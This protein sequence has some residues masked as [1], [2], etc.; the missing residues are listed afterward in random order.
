MS[1]SSFL[2]QLAQRIRTFDHPVIERLF[3]P[4]RIALSPTKALALLSLKQVRAENRFA[5]HLVSW[6]TF[7]SFLIL[8]NLLIDGPGDFWAPIP[9]GLWGIAIAFHGRRALRTRRR[10]YEAEHRLLRQA[11]SSEEETDIERLRHK[12]LRASEE[13]REV[14]RSANPDVA[15]EISHGE[16]EAL[17]VVAW[18]D[19]AEKLLGST[20]SNDD[21][22]RDAARRL[23]EPGQ[24]HRHELERLVM[25][26]DR[27][28]SRRAALEGEAAERRAKVESFILAIENVKLAHGGRP[29]SAGDVPSAVEASIRERVALLREPHT[30]RLQEEVQ[31]AQDLQRSILPAAA[32]EVTGLRVAHIYRPSSEVGGDFYDFYPTDSGRL[33]IA[34]GDA[35]GHGLDSSMVSSMAK[36]A[37]YMQVSARRALDEI[38]VELNQMMFDTLD[39]RRLMT[40]TL[41]ELDPEQQVVSWVNAGQVYPLLRRQGEI[42]ELDQPGYPLGVRRQ[43]RYEIRQLEL[44]PGDLLLLLTDG[45]FEAADASGEPYGWD[46][47]ADRLRQ[48]PEAEPQ[49]L[50][51]HLVGDLDRYLGTASPQDDITLI[52][53]ALTP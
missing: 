23:S 50:L 33:L 32:P 5:F 15:A 35:S 6:A 1:P 34:L 30:S 31:L 45:Y 16:T 22:R 21:L 12:L 25:E 43:T 9:V 27:T 36:S 38:L 20:R 48:L 4:L 51:E 18:L 41:L 24:A 2:K 49:A 52:A 7:S 8:A 42:L 17:A 28:D 37:L 53:L 44:E 11:G 47:L 39:R 13:A 46:R 3:P 40:F 29:E 14:L 26:L 19:R 10:R